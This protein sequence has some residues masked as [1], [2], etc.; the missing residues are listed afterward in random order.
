MTVRPATASDYDAV[1]L[2]QR[3]AVESCLRPLYDGA[4]IDAWLLT[5]DAAKFLRVVGTGEVVLVAEEEGAVV[6]FASYHVEMSLV[7]MWYVDPS[8][9][10]RGV[11]SALLGACEDGLA[12]AGCEEATTEASLFALPRFLSHG[13]VAV[14]EFDKPAFGG[15]FRVTRMSKSLR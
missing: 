12:A 10:G 14:E 8:V 15:V 6:G 3:R 7:G 4:A 13:W 11:G 5:I 9:L 2:V 1:A